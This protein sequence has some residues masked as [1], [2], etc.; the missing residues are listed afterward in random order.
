MVFPR[1]F[2]KHFF[3]I[4]GTHLL[5]SYNE[6]FSKGQFSISQ[7]R[8]VIC[9]IPKDYSNLTE[10]SN[11][12][13][14]TLLNVDYKI[15]AKI[16]GRRIE[17][18]LPTLIH[19][20]QTGFVK[21]RFIGQ[22]VR[23]LNDLMTYAESNNL[24]GILLFID[25]RKAF[26]TIE[27]DF[28]Q[29]SIEM[30]N[31]GPNIRKWISI[32]TNVESGVMNAGFMTNYFKVSRG[33]RQGCLLSP[34][35]FVLPVELLGL[36]IRQDR[37]CR[38]IKLPDGQEA[39]ISQF[40][41]DTTLIVQNT[42]SLKAAINAINSFG[43]ISGLQ[44]NEKK[45]KALRI[46]ASRN[47]TAEPLKFQCPKDPIKFLGTFL[48][49]S[50]AQNNNNNFFIK[51]RKMETKLN[52]WLSRDLTLFGRTMLAKSLG[53]SQLIYTASMLSVPELAI[54]QTQRKLFS[55]L[56][57]KKRDKIKRQVLCWPLSRGGLGFPC[58]RTAIKALRLSWMRLLNK[59]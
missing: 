53:L 45:T 21:V 1:N 14:L 35:L 52:I 54:Q 37:L 2:T 6:A 8:G 43:S 46:G 26:D 34:L 51:I 7:R 16:I 50:E 24:P 41:D 31:F 17:S 38:G 30:F 10:L 15:L 39:K 20:D 18:V 23:L 27:W 44:L 32:Y 36:K 42:A 9:L 56:W 57:K 59:S 40:A 47:N 4:I 5:N 11:W 58:F 22:N 29:K 12:R 48:S 49:H 33:V 25:F 3:D 19:S 13:L 55:F 28:I